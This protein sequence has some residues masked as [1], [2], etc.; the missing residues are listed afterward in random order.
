MSRV[1]STA[2]RSPTPSSDQK[3]AQVFASRITSRRASLMP[4]RVH[5]PMRRISRSPLTPYGAYP[6]A[7]G[8]GASAKLGLADVSC[9]WVV[10]GDWFGAV[11]GVGWVVTA[12][13]D[14]GAGAIDT[15]GS[16]VVP[17]PFATLIVLPL[18]H[19]QST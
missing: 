13:A 8:G 18:P 11:D 12:G 3:P 6:W 4:V 2:G 1:K 17:S 5:W 19:A 7:S 10:W 9:G 14:S 16:P 15:A